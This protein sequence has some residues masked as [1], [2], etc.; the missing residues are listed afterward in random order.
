MGKK[1]STATEPENHHGKSAVKHLKENEMV[2]HVP[3]DIS[4]YCT[5]TLLS[6]WTIKCDI[7]GKKLNKRGNELEVSCKYIVKRPFHM[8]LNV[9]KIIE[10]YLPSTTK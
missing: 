9:Q 5:S 10:D 2:G 4:K 7:T 1:I 3:R 6:G 8:L